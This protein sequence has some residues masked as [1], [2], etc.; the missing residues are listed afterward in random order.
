M[1]P[2]Q[3]QR[4]AKRATVG[5]ARVGG[6]GHN[7]S[8]DIFLAFSTGNKLPVQNIASKKRLDTFSPKAVGIEVIDDT[9]IDGLLE[10]AAD[11]TEEAIYNA[12]CM[13]E[14][15]VGNQGHKIEALPLERVEGIM[16]KYL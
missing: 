13:A 14:T 5:L 8:G 15:M 3:L 9:T 12:L 11:A 6:Q 1:N 16:E 2:T 7:S 10:A 4:I